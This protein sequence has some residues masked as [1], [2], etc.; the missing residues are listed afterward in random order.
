MPSKGGYVAVKSTANDRGRRTAG[1]CT[2]RKL[3]I[4]ARFHSGLPG[5]KGGLRPRAAPCAP[6]GRH[7]RSRSATPR[8]DPTASPGTFSPPLAPFAQ[9][10]TSDDDQSRRADD[11][12][13]SDNEDS[14][15]VPRVW[16]VQVGVGDMRG[17]GGT[18]EV[19]GTRGYHGGNR[20]WSTAPCTPPPVPA[21]RVRPTPPRSRTH[22]RSPHHTPHLNLNQEQR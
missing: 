4:D 7:S 12:R 13:A 16:R 9:N 1:Y 19:L 21:M 17:L 22:V 2:H 14:P 18:Q 11:D 10:Q 6:R 3:N 20:L 5:R 15:Q 8:P